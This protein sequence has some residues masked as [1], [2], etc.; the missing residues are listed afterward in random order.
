MAQWAMAW[1]SG[2]PF[3]SWRPDCSVS[4]TDL[5][6]GRKAEYVQV[7]GSLLLQGRPDGAPG[8]YFGPP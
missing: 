2:N 7:L 1:N 8:I 5:C 4:N 3:Q 6:L